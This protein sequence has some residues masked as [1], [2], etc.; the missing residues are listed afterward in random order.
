MGNRADEIG[1]VAADRL[2]IASKAEGD[3]GL[4]LRLQQPAG[5]NDTL[6]AD[7]HVGEEDTEIGLIDPELLLHRLR[8]QPDLG[9]DDPPARPD[10]MVAIQ[11]LDRIG[12]VDRGVRFGEADRCVGRTGMGGADAGGG[13]GRSIKIGLAEA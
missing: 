7:L 2:D 12:V 6:F 4:D 3:F 11:R 13:A 10:P 8:R 9:A 1:R 5:G